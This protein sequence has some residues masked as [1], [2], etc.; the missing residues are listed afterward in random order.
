MKKAATELD[1]KGEKLFETHRSSLN[2]IHIE[3]SPSQSAGDLKQ[4]QRLFS[5]ALAADPSY[6]TAAFNL[7]QVD[8][9]L[10][11]EK[12]SLEAYRRAIEIDPAYVDAR[13][14]YAAVLIENGDAD[15]AI[16][17]LT[18]AIRLEPS[19]DQAYALIVARVLG[20]GHMEPMYPDG[21]SGHF[22]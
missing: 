12:G 1:S 21:R 22:H 9:L 17:Q 10:S 2:L 14:Q 15:E 5:Q 7:G 6:S 11:D 3:S 16:R 4:A 20:Q 18:E 19:N 13:L 8:Q